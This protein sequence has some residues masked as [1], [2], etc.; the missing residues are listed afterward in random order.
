M[1]DISET[2]NIVESKDY[3]KLSCLYLPTLL[4]R[5]CHGYHNIQLQKFLTNQGR[6]HYQNLPTLSY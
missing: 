3:V 6:L 1:T 4:P 5:A 2:K